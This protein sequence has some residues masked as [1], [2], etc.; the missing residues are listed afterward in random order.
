MFQKTK[1]FKLERYLSKIYFQAYILILV[2]ILI[3]TNKS[4]FLQK[5]G[6]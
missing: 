2:M 6:T 4:H 1:Y 3:K 5:L